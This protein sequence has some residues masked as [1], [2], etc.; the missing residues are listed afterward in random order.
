MTRKKHPEQE[1]TVKVKGM[2][3]D[4]CEV[5]LERKLGALPGVKRVKASHAKGT[6]KITHKNNIDDDRIAAAIKEAGYDTT[7]NKKDRVKE[8]G[9]G[10]II[11]LAIYLVLRQFELTSAFGVSDGMSLGFILLLGLVASISSC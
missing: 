6:I 3:C 11:V 2:T 1:K 7:T 4:S 9:A 10:L 8:L 5:L